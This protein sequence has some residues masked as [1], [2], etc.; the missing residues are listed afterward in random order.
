VIG[1]I[2]WQKVPAM[3]GTQLDDRAAMIQAELETAKRLRTEAEALLASTARRRRSREGSRSDPTAARAGGRRVAAESRRPAQGAQ[4]E[5]RAIA[6]QAKIAQAEAAA[7]PRSVR[8]PQ[9]LPVRRR[10]ED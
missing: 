1:I 6:A 4:M 9:R 2:I 5:R 10:R 7:V 8:L 3:I